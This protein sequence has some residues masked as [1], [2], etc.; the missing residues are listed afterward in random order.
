MY[1]Y[2]HNYIVQIATIIIFVTKWSPPDANC[3]GG[4]F[5]PSTGANTLLAL[6]M[7]IAYYNLCW[8][9]AFFLGALVLLLMCI[10]RL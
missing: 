9:I 3:T 1:N 8:C 10:Q 7:V 6:M 2:M 4:P 5:L